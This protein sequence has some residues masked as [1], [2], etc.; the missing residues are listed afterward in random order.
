MENVKSETLTTEIIRSVKFTASLYTDEWLVYKG[1]S[2]IYSHSIVKHN[3]GE[4][5]NGRVHTNTIER[6]WQV[7]KRGIVGIYHFTSK[8]HLQRYV[9]EFEFRYNTRKRSESG[10]FNFLLANTETRTNYK[11]LING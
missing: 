1:V 8:K 10:R 6:F 11:G 7:L 5:V 9:D 4:Y 2:R 3:Q